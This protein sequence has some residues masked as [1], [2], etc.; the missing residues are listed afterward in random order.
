MPTSRPVII[1]PRD[2]EIRTGNGLLCLTSNLGV[3]HSNKPLLSGSLNDRQA[4]M[5][6]DTGSSISI[7]SSQTIK[8]YGIVAKMHPSCLRI[9]GVSGSVKVM[10]FIFCQL[11]WD[12]CYFNQK[13]LVLDCHTTPGNILLGWDF[14]TLAG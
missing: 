13:L 3:H 5:F 12:N 8:Q 11:V 10:G 2:N 1:D 14:F 4:N 6:L 7:I 9:H